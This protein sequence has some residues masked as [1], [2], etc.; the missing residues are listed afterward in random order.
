MQ[1][2]DTDF[3]KRSAHYNYKMTFSLWLTRAT[4]FKQINK[5]DNIVEINLLLHAVPVF[6]KD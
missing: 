2:T 6:E 1:H 4:P 3:I 5:S